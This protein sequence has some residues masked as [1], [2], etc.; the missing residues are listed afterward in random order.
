MTMNSLADVWRNRQDPD[1]RDQPLKSALCWVLSGQRVDSL[2]LKSGASSFGPPRA[3]GEADL[4]A[5]SG[6]P[7][8][9]SP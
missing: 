2:W 5:Q 6:V 9:H 4:V 7:K 1:T 3:H 8:N